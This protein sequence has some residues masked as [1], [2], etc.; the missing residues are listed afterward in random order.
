MLQSIRARLTAWYAGVFA[1]FATIF[2]VACYTFLARATGARI[3]EA[4][5]ETA[6]DVIRALAAERAA[7]VPSGPAVFNVMREFRLGDAAVAALDRWS[8]T[9]V[10][11]YE[12]APELPERHAPDPPP[13]PPDFRTVLRTAPARPALVTIDTDGG[14][15][16]VFTVPYRFGR[17]ELIIGAAQS[18]G[19]QERTLREARMMLAVGAPLMLVLAAAGG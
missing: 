7:G 2:A 19:A 18:L 12:T 6:T 1:L 15:V 14:P 4:L 9:V 13:S 17:R 8:G 16:R 11:A 5:R 10:I 3:D